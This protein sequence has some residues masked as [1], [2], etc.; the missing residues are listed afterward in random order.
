VK[1]HAPAGLLFT[2]LAVV[3]TWPLARNLGSAVANTG[4]PLINIWIL[5]WDW[6][7]TLHHP[8]SLFQANAFYP[9]KYALAFS[10]NLYG[11]AL[12]LFPLRALG[13]GAVG[14]MN[15]AMLLGFALSGIAAYLLGELV[16]RSAAAGIAAGVFYAFVPFRFS[17]LSQVQFVWGWPLPLLLYALLRYKREPTGSNAALFGLVFVLNGLANIHAFLFGSVAIAITA[18]IVRPRWRLL[19]VSTTLSMLLLLPFL[20]PYWRASKLYGMQRNAQE[21]MQYSARAGDWLHVSQESRVYARWLMDPSIDAERRLFPG[22]LAIVLALGGLWAGLQPS[23]KGRREEG[24]ATGVALAWVALGYAGSLGLHTFFHRCLFDWVP[25]FRAIRVPA[26]WAIVAYVGLAVLVALGTEALGR[27]RWAVIVLLLVELHAA[28]LRWQ[29]LP[30]EVPPVYKWLATEKP[31]AVLEL[32][33]RDQLADYF[34]LLGATAHHRRIANGISGFDP[35]EFQRLNELSHATPISDALAGEL[36]SIGVDTLIVHGDRANASIRDWLR[37]E[38]LPYAGRFDSAEGNGDWVFR[39]DGRSAAHRDVLDRYLSGGTTYNASTFGVLQFPQ[40]G[41]TIR[42][43]AF[44][45]GYALSPYGIK[46]VDL[47]FD[48]GAV[49]L[50]ATLIADPGLSRL[51]PWYDATPLPRFVAGFP[52]RPPG[53]RAETDVQVEI[54]DGK[55]GV[56]RLLSHVFVWPRDSDQ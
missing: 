40:S 15:V 6:Y 30:S 35:P 36:R 14:A 12:F 42:R 25:G 49:R 20:V 37:R 19:L 41:E 17:H 52:T 54:E 9:A 16:T 2:A 5:D 10:E 44:F 31:H 23:L 50:P 1:R 51:Y 33:I 29:L 7:A 27:V 3:M 48:N 24:A 32:P 28:P 45:S 38:R 46:R 47:L 4:D 13:V 34:Y 21:T 11:I 26:R 8:L 53:V 43:G 39:M 18:L 22:A 55:G 56:T